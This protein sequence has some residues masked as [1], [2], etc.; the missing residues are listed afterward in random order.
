MVMVTHRHMD[1]GTKTFQRTFQ[2]EKHF[3]DP[4]RNETSKA[5][6]SM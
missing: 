4:G 1:E 6:T 5:V 3:R 2:D